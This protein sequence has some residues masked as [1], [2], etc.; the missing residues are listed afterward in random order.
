MLFLVYLSNH[1]DRG[2]LN[3]LIQP[4]K[5]EFG[6]SDFMMGMLAG[7]AF[8]IFYATA[9]IP[10]A[11][12]ADR[13][14]RVNVIAV[15]MTVWSGMTALSGYAGNI[16]SLALFRVGVGAGE[17][18]CSPPSHSLIADY[19][20][21]E[22]RGRAM[23]V[24]AMATQAGA[25]FGWLLGG[26]LFLWLGWRWT[27]VAAGVP[28]IF[29]ALIVKMTVKE[30]ARGRTEGGAVDVEPMPF[31]E[32]LRHLLRQ[33]SYM[34]LQAGGALHAVAGYGLGVWVATFLIRIHGLEIHEIGSW[35][36]G[37]AIVAGMPGML[38]AGLLSDRLTPRDP[39][40][41]VGIPAVSAL[42][43]APF[44]V[45][46]LFLGDVTA[47][48]ICYAI[49]AVLGMAFSAPTFAMTQA[50][51]KVRARS[52]AVAVHLLMV[53]LVGL[54]LGPVIIGGLNDML[55]EDLGDEA[56]RYTMLLAVLTNVFA[57][58][59]YYLSARTVKHDIEN[60]DR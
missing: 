39:R 18:G 37:I 26:W 3:I 22:R 10:I 27:F 42:I 54:G 59:F 1:I 7:P 31:G 11:R 36:G 8:A 40:W 33:R 43:S 48:L 49:H 57:V 21:P 20:P 4:I 35:L 12:L 28:G 9:G 34:W 60:R 16:I 17:A 46:F 56:I 24:Y 47:A 55:H 53:N 50:V 51:V 38:L 29:L 23:G 6:A 30:P 41:Y 58:G 25:A 52:L 45:A 15:S 13:T 19:F 14:S 44:T 5:E 2:I 32:A